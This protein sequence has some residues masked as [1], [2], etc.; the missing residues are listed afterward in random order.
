[1]KVITLLFFVLLFNSNSSSA[2]SN[3]ASTSSRDFYE[4]VICD[5]CGYSEARSIASRS[6]YV[7]T[8]QCFVGSSGGP[9]DEAC[10][11]AANK[12]VVYD[13]AQ[14]RAYGFYIRHKN[15]GGISLDLTIEIADMQQIPADVIT[16]HKTI[17]NGYKVMTNVT[18]SLR[19][20]F[21]FDSLV[22]GSNQ[23]NLSFNSL[24][25]S[26]NT[27]ATDC[28]NSPEMKAWDLAHNLSAR[29]KL[30]IEANDKAD[31]DSN[32]KGSFQDIR[33]TGANFQ[34]AIYSIGIGGTVE[35]FDTTKQIVTDFTVHSKYFGAGTR[36]Q[37]VFD[38][39][40]LDGTVDA[41]VNARRTVIGGERLFDIQK[42]GGSVGIMKA[43]QIS[44]CL[45]DAIDKT[46]PKTV[47]SSGGTGG[48]GGGGSSSS[49]NW[50]NIPLSQGHG[51]TGGGGGG[52]SC[53][54]TYYDLHGEPMFSFSGPCP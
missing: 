32:Y 49:P 28:S 13:I 9:E 29:G 51:N 3:E 10:Y 5:N 27:L 26:A 14:E 43:S 47:S 21:S 48:G 18:R 42:S 45:A 15:Q 24:A 20:D 44:K 7:P 34:A 2:S 52:D 19:Q 35:Y 1:M 25:T 36:N 46:F 11:S 31:R 39:K 8:M 23:S 30:G 38:L 37:V 54:H 50:G 41:E 16:L 4:S 22:S 6:K 40:M 17:V 53:T 12:L 33:I